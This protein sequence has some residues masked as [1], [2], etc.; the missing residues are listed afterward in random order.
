MEGD[1][2]QNIAMLEVQQYEALFEL[3]FILWS[4]IYAFRWNAYH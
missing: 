2:M 1:V 4:F 3:H